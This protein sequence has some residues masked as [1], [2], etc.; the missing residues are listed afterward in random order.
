MSTH[1]IVR[2]YVDSKSVKSV[3]HDPDFNIVQ[4]PLIDVRVA[5]IQNDNTKDPDP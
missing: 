4:E 1:N 3:F 5:R 2:S